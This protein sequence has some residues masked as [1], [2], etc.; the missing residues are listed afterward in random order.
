[1][2]QGSGWSSNLSGR[3]CRDPWIALGA[4]GTVGVT[5][6]TLLEALVVISRSSIPY[7]NPYRNPH[8]FTGF[9]PLWIPRGSLAF[10]WEGVGISLTLAGLCYGFQPLRMVLPEAQQS[11]SRRT[12]GL[13]AASGITPN[14]VAYHIP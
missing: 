11:K 8:G 1:M 13:L 7:S 3:R 6:I 4:I 9:N 12:P 2:L 14:W 10:S 5:L